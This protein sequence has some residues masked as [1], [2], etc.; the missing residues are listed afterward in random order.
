MF[1]ATPTRDLSTL[2]RALNRSTYT[3]T[4]FNT[5]AAT[6]T[7][8]LSQSALLDEAGRAS[9]VGKDRLTFFDKATASL[10]PKF[11]RNNDLSTITD[12]M[13]L[14]GNDFFTKSLD[15]NHQVKA[16]Q[17][18]IERHVMGSVFTILN[19]EERMNNFTGNRCI[20]LCNDNTISL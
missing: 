8:F 18:H 10:E 20:V 16:L 14:I 2:R 7:T 1:N 15:F 17:H 13:K 5:V 9:L 3:T 11:S 12:P 6:T 4:R 19:V